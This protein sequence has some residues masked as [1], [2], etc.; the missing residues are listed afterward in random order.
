L[1]KIISNEIDLGDLRFTNEDNQ[2]IST[3][4]TDM[5]SFMNFKDKINKIQE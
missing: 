5:Q 3:W 2:K 4:E 1:N